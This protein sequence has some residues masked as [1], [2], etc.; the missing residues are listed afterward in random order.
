MGDRSLQ[1][2]NRSYY[3][4]IMAS[5]TK[6]LYIGV[7]NDLERRAT[8]HRTGAREGF[9]KK[10]KMRRLVYCEAVASIADAI[11]REKQLKGWRRS[12]KIALIETANPEWDDLAEG[13]T[14]NSETLRFAQGD[15]RLARRGHR[16]RHSER[17]EERPA[18]HQRGRA[19]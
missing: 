18:R 4:Y 8:E 3:V 12:K 6:R 10:Y 19:V 7:T 13:W 9:T 1:A 14:P 2:A 17:S 5:R 15:G 11:R 16:F